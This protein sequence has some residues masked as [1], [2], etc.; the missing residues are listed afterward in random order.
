MQYPYDLISFE[1]FSLYDSL[2]TVVSSATSA[3]DAVFIA[4]I[5]EF[6]ALL[7]CYRSSC[8]Y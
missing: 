2:T 8:R 6:Y 7:A 3:I 1:P 4:V 5:L